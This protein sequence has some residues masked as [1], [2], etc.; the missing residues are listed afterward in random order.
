MSNVR[1]TAQS[2]PAKIGGR[3]SKSGTPWPGTYSPRSTSSS[4]VRGATRTFTPRAVRGLDDLEQLLL[5]EAA[6][7]D[8]QL[9]EPSLASSASRAPGA[10]RTLARE[11]V[12]DPAAARAERRAQVRDL[13]GLADEQRAA[14]HA[15]ERSSEPVTVS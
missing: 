9:V 15:D 12:V 13:L 14:A 1:L 7:G 6:V 3:S 11:L 8:D 2:V 5:A 10:E 4:V